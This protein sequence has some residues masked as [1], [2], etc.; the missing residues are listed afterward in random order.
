MTG[1]KEKAGWARKLDAAM[2][3]VARIFAWIAFV[4]VVLMAVHV[5]ASVAL[6]WATGRD[7]PVTTEMATYYYMVSL[8]FLP[9]AYVEWRGKHLYAEFFY[10]ILPRPLRRVMDLVNAVLVAGFLGFL[11]WRTAVDAIERTRSADVISTVWGNLAVWP[12][13]WIVPIG[14]GAAFLWMLARGIARAVDGVPETQP[15]RSEEY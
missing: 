8:T 2:T 13:R 1:I 3:G 9:L 10:A 4:A 14:L 5:A 15:A 6:R 12:A 7:I 11:T